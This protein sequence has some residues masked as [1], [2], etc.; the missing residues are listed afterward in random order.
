VNE[1]GFDL[2]DYL[3]NYFYENFMTELEDESHYEVAAELEKFF[4]YFQDGEMVKAEQDFEKLPPTQ[5]WIYTGVTSGHINNPSASILVE[6]KSNT[7]AEQQNT[8]ENEVESDM[9]ENEESNMDVDD[10]TVDMNLDKNKDT[11]GWT[12]VTNKRNK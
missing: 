5:S 9:D 8:N 6:N 1:K 2:A 3:D 7:T 4:L 11:D 10:D 12:L